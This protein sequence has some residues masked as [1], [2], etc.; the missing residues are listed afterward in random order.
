MAGTIPFASTHVS[1]TRPR[2][3]RGI[4]SCS[5][6]LPVRWLA[7]LL[8]TAALAGCG[9]PGP[10][11]TAKLFVHHYVNNHPMALQYFD[12]RPD[13]VEHI[14]PE[15]RD[16]NARPLLMKMFRDSVLEED[17]GLMRVNTARVTARLV[18]QHGPDAVVYL[19]GQIEYVYR[20]SPTRIVTLD[21]L[22]TL[23]K[24][25]GRWK[26]HGAVLGQGG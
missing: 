23:H 20:D 24:E 25:D 19:G 13:G 7:L 9:S 8:L 14:T 26:V 4:L 1:N 11:A 18:S 15:E 6:L 3:C 2:S 10:E 21:N 16:F 17:A 12:L 5:I 22:V